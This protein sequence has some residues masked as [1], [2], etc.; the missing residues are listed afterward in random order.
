[1]KNLELYLHIPFCRKKCSYC[2]FLSAPATDEVQQR[3]VMQ[4]IQEIRTVSKLY[5]DYEVVTVFIGGGTPSILDA[6]LVNSLLEQLYHDFHI[7]P[8]AE[9]TMECNPGTLDAGRLRAYKTS[10]INRLSMGMQSADDREL[11]MLGRIHTHEQSVSNY[12]L[13]RD[14]GFENINIDIISSLPG[15]KLQD[16]EYTLHEILKLQPEHISAY[17]LII[18]EG[19]PFYERFGQAEKLR[20]IGKQQLL[21]P[22][23]EEERGMY[24]LTKEL[25]KSEG[26]QRYEISNYAR[27]GFECRHNI[28]YWTRKDYLGIGLGAASFIGNVRFSN[29]SDLNEYLAECFSL[30][31][32]EHREGFSSKWHIHRECLDTDAQMEEFMFLGLRMMCGVIAKDFY[33]QFSKSMEDVYEDVLDKQLKQNLIKKTAHGYCLTDYGIDLSNYVMA[34]YLLG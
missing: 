30:E 22:S 28:G 14:M 18:E 20:E 1:M 31:E 29:G 3:Y 8:D 25:L 32:N 19:T 4:M 21:L 24:T 9:I 11:E 13:A 6:A 16:Y 10:G 2:D 26:Y 27:E 34:Q 7:L 33:Q 5:A 15:Q 23:E 17:S 12:M